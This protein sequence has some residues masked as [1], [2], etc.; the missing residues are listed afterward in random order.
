[1]LIVN[2]FISLVLVASCVAAFRWGGFDE[3][4]GAGA[5]MLA[6][7]A[8]NIVPLSVSYVHYSQTDLGF[9]GIDAALFIGLLILALRSD[10]FWPLWAAAF[11]LVAMLVHVGSLFQHGNFAWAYYVALIFW[12]FPVTISLGAGSWLEGRFRNNGPDQQNSYRV[13]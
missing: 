11:Q 2:F 3:R 10:R 4:F 5:I 1:M 9:F 13:A 7:L 6:T 12:S 8:S